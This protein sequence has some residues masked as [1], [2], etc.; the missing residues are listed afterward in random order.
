MN[1]NN[2]DKQT[3]I[4]QAG[5][6]NTQINIFS[7]LPPQAQRGLQ[8]AFDLSWDELKSEAKHLAC[9][10]AAFA[11]SPV[12]WGF[13][14][15]IY[16]QL[17]GESFNEDNLKDRWLKSLRKLHLVI[18]VEEKCLIQTIILETSDKNT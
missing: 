18:T 15:R 3:N 12:Y 9:V 16:Q 14:T 2:I 8:S 7:S 6:Y 17:Q 13:V 1:F 11:A 5:E 4:T 10:L